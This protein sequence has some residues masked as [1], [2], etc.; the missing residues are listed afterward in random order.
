MIRR[1][2]STDTEQCCVPRDAKRWSCH[3]RKSNGRIDLRV[4][5]LTAVWSSEQT[6]T[7]PDQAA[8]IGRVNR[9]ESIVTMAIEGGRPAIEKAS[10]VWRSDQF[11]NNNLICMSCF[12]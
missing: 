5:S 9:I 2:A 6:F 10:T 4:R 12:T 1:T 8:V 7:V 11:A 3:Q